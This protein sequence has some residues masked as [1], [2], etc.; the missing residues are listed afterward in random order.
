[1]T[2]INII[3]DTNFEELSETTLKNDKE[4][5]YETLNTEFDIYKLNNYN[6]YQI[7]YNQ[8]LN[9]LLY[10]DNYLDYEKDLYNIETINI[11][12]LILKKILTF[13]NPIIKNIID[14]KKSSIIDKLAI[15]VNYPLNVKI[16]SSQAKHNKQ[17]INRK[18]S[19]NTYFLI[20][21]LYNLQNSSNLPFKLDNFK[22]INQ[23]IIKLLNSINNLSIIDTKINIK[24]SKLNYNTVSDIGNLSIF[25]IE[26]IDNEA[27]KELYL[28][29]LNYYLTNLNNS[30]LINSLTYS[31]N[32]Q[33]NNLL[34][35]NQKK[36]TDINFS[37]NY[38]SIFNKF[39]SYKI[40]D[41]FNN[42]SYYAFQSNDL[43][44]L[45]EEILIYSID[46][47]S[48]QNKIN[49]ILVLNENKKEYNNNRQIIDKYNL[50]YIQLEYLTRK[51]FPN[52]FNPNSKE[53][54]FYKHKSFNLDD[55]PKKY[56][57]II[58]IDYKKLQNYTNENINN[59]CTHKNLLKE[60][61]LTN[62]KYLIIKELN[63]LIQGN[64]NKTDEYYK[65]ILC[66][67]N[68]ICPHILEYYNLL[69]AKNQETGNDFSIRQ[70]LINK[71]MTNAKINM[72]YYC[73]VCGEEL[74]RSLDLE[75][76]IEY[77]DKV[78]LNTSEYTDST[79]EM[80]RNNTMHIIYSYIIFTELNINISKK[81][82]I[83]YVFTTILT[84]INMI[85]KSLRKAKIYTEDHINNL[86]DF[87]SI[88][89]IYATLIFIMTKY[90]FI[91]FIQNKKSSIAGTNDSIIIE[92]TAGRISKNIIIP[93]KV[94]I[95]SNKDLLNL[96]KL[97]F[98]EAYDI[99]ISTNNILLFKLKYNKQQEKIK[100]LLIKTYSII[101]KNDQMSLSE[102][103]DKLSNSQLLIYSS[104][105]NYLYL[106]KSI[107]PLKSINNNVSSLPIKYFGSELYTTNNNQD[108]KITNYEKVLNINNINSNKIDNLFNKFSSSIIDET[109]LNKIL[110]NNKI[111][112]YN[113]Y[114]IISFNLFYYHIKHE[115]Y[116]L[117]IYEYIT[118]EQQPLDDIK[119]IIKNKF[120]LNNI[121][122]DKFKLASNNKNAIDNQELYNYIKL[123]Q[124]IKLYEIEL[125]NKN[126]QYNLYPFSLIK[127]NNS[128]Y[129][130]KKNIH[131]NIYFCSKDGYPH[132]FNIYTFIDQT[133][134]KIEINKKQ[135]DNKINDI[136][137]Y[138]FIDY[139][140][141]KC[142]TEKNNLLSSK[143]SN[144]NIIKLINNNNDKDGFFNLYI[145][146]CPITIKNANQDEM[147]YHKFNSINDE[148]I[149]EICKIKYNDLLNKNNDIYLQYSKEYENYKF[150]KQKIINTQLYNIKQRNDTEYQ[151]NIKNIYI[152]N[153]QNINILS[154]NINNNN[155]DIIKLINDINY[156]TI[157]V[158][159]T[160]QFTNTITGIGKQMNIIFLQKLGLTEGY[161]YNE[162]QFQ[163]I[164]NNYNLL[165]INKLFSYFR[166]III[167]Y[168]LL[169]YNKNLTKHHDL[170]F[171]NIIT[172]LHENIKIKSELE[173]FLPDIK[174]NIVNLLTA[175]KLQYDNEYITKFL[176][177]LILQF[178]LDLET[179]N[180]SKF[181][182]KLNIFIQFILS[183]ILKFDELFTNYNY[184]Q[185]KQMFNEDKFDI[186][187]SFQT[188]EEYDNEDDDELF[189]YNDLNIQ[190]EDEESIDE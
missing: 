92:K 162:K 10:N 106:I 82:L 180:Q 119:E 50:K 11:K 114:K 149:C 48:I 184:S 32:I 167:Y 69:F 67:Y 163:E 170:D 16:I 176:I 41:Y 136:A 130:Y 30:I 40:N 115:L 158:N 146:V 123:S 112:D 135:L 28:I 53:V 74:G 33:I 131:L 27:L 76:N 122:L 68:L 129:F 188:N 172:K 55:L 24:L 18:L 2:E 14:T 181:D 90:P 85:E 35:K 147:Q 7:P 107:Y 66:S 20:N 168:N 1:M 64:A 153:L 143:I 156:D 47:E 173:N 144:E 124:L 100:E 97:R 36:L 96:I 80:V 164:K 109:L 78:K 142:N 31:K 186:N 86:L 81:Y 4:F 12:K 152:N 169:K 117:P 84:N 59:K 65:C 22:Y 110:Q 19:A 29:Y 138:K 104:I 133:Q 171:L 111:N 49:N 190:F 154:N 148:I 140:C 71:Y 6:K 46:N 43:L 178:I 150:K 79:L 38:I 3:L 15:N 98:K 155:S 126:I 21:G 128:R 88:I 91:S 185:L 139:K 89:F 17:L 75:Q 8:I 161:E 9:D 113:E 182:N 108:L 118:I 93:K 77:K 151:K 34:Y 179:I 87:N 60:L 132:N 5:F 157:L 175:L 99:I 101:A 13:F 44:N 183:K 70:H 62:N 116:N 166:T 58:L 26:K 56:K 95:K 51:R 120:V 42:H 23:L 125:I 37:Q 174:Y 160:K 63:K 39:L 137:Q 103:T 159:F 57:E 134:N 94:E 121:Y 127:L 187:M 145:N 45:Y 61:N 54:I 73:K 25:D 52:L 177:K 141:S 72:I 165:R 189:G 83:N 102:K 105:Y